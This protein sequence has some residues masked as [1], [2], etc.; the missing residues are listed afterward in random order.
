MQ[1]AWPWAL[2]VIGGPLILGIALAW[3]KLRSGKAMRRRDPDTP[4]DDPSRGM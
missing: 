3:G 1:D 2:V 4:S